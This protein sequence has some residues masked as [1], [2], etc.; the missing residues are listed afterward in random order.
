M[1]DIKVNCVKLALHN[2]VIITITNWHQN[3]KEKLNKLIVDV[4]GNNLFFCS[5]EAFCNKSTYQ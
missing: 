1:Q 5:F 3:R 2:T 4:S